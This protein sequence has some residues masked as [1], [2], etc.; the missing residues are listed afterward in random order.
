MQPP[1]P[2]VT[3]QSANQFTLT[4]ALQAQDPYFS[5]H[6]DGLPV[7]AGVVQLG[8]VVAYAERLLGRRYKFLGLTSNKFLQ[9]VRPPVTL[10]LSVQYE[11]E[12]QRLKFAYS[13]P[14]G[15]CSRGAIN[16]EE[17]S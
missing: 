12:H 11:P 16:V 4:L 15:V 10:Q 7:L 8:W 3:Q 17:M 9:L 2:I 6:F 5:G 13:L 1:E 14:N